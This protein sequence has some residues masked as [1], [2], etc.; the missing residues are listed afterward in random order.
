MLIVLSFVESSKAVLL[1][2]LD[3]G[4]SYFFLTCW[5]EEPTLQRKNVPRRAVPKIR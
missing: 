5:L 2:A 4:R 3:V 1:L